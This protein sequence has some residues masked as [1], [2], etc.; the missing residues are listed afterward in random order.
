MNRGAHE[1]ADERIAPRLLAPLPRDL[2]P[3]IDVFGAGR[4]ARALMTVAALR[5]DS[6]CFRVW[7]RHE[8]RAELLRVHLADLPPL[9]VEIVVAPAPPADG[10]GPLVLALGAR[11]SRRSRQSRK[12]ALFA[13]N[14]AMIEGVAG[15]LAGRA[16]I[17][18]TN[19]CTAIAARLAA[20]GVQA[21]GVGV[22]ND[23]LRFERDLTERAD[24]D[25]LGE[26][27]RLV[28]AHNPFE[29]GFGSLDAARAAWA[30]A[31]TREAYRD[32]ANRQDRQR[33]ALEPD[34]LVSR[35]LPQL[36]ETAWR[37]LGRLHQALDPARRWYARQRIAS[38]YLENGV[39]CGR[40]I[41]ML[42]D[43]MT[44]VP[45][46]RADVTVEAALDPGFGEGPCVL[47]WP[48]DA[49]AG[50][51]RA[52]RL[53]AQSA[54]TLRVAASRYR[55]D[56]PSAPAG[57]PA[58]HLAAGGVLDI[59][60]EGDEIG[61]ILPD[62]VPLATIRD[63]WRPGAAVQ[64]TVESDPAHL[65][66]R[67]PA[68]E[69]PARTIPQ[70]RGKNPFEHRDL[71]L[72]PLAGG[73]RLGRFQASGAAALIDDAARRITIA[74]PPGPGRRDE[75]RKLLRDQI[76]T[77]AYAGAGAMILHAGLISLDGAHLL[78]IGGSGAGKT[79]AALHALCGGRGGYGSSERVLV[80]MR[81]GRLTALGVPESLTIFPGSLRGL[82]PF[83]EMLAGRDPD[84][85]WLRA[86][87]LRLTRDEVVRRLGSWQI[88]EPAPVDAVV[89]LRFDGALPEAASTRPDLSIADLAK[90]VAEND[91][92]AEDDV[93]AAWLGWFAP[94]PSPGTLPGLLAAPRRELVWR[95]PAA[96]ALALAEQ[97]G[98][99][100]I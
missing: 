65:L 91:L 93:R 55:L 97:Q 27:I 53:P 80:W 62:I 40:A 69:G 68:P 32:L 43:L 72:E 25:G 83:A 41:L 49:L 48:L 70:H 42:C 67:A 98:K 2:P 47:G 99:K 92:T 16:V 34:G 35:L 14:M 57:P 87:K 28:G 3:A 86:G 19:P 73:R 20:S 66:A 15:A 60:C 39:A 90:A 58:F 71:I 85:D 50:Q 56:A 94:R 79:T 82:D 45:L 8:A 75:L 46:R 95:S 13:D 29:L 36:H 52:L 30:L 51:P 23:Q 5:G 22:M 26:G 61:D 4:V 84:G 59:A 24:A 9:S 96:L 64:V 11:T 37:D 74:A 18:V 10:R 12:D 54:V 44:G 88:D 21:Y 6:R 77:P 76:L 1:G 81:E 17:V 38:R 63:G 100:A 78:L 31:F 89:L 33:P 7:C